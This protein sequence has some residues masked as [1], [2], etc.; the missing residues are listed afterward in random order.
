[1]RKQLACDAHARFVAELAVRVAR[2]MGLAEV[3]VRRCALAGLFHDVGKAFVSETILDKPGPLTEHEWRLVRE[4]PQLGAELLAALSPELSDVAEIIRDHH[5]RPDG[6]GYPA[7][8]RAGEIRIEARIVAACDAWAAMRSDR[9]Y[10]PALSFEEALAELRRGRGRQF[11]GLV[12]AAFERLSDRG[13]ALDGPAALAD[14]AQGHVP[15][16]PAHASLAPLG[17]GA[18]AGTENSRPGTGSGARKP[19]DGA[20]RDA[21]AAPSGDVSKSA[22]SCHEVAAAT[23]ATAATLGSQSRLVRPGSTVA[24]ERGQGGKQEI[25]WEKA[26]IH[27]GPSFPVVVDSPGARTGPVLTE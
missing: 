14:G 3:T 17:P 26:K 24:Q 8:R 7:G 19:Q 15:S 5:E 12:V 9:P 1:V 18:R 25:Q 23:Q 20:S 2:E 16:P 13:S 27:N 4:H 21:A 22:D 11:D 10:R 6:C